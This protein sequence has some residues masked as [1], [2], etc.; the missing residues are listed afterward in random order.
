M[1]FLSF[2]IVAVILLAKLR[3]EGSGTACEIEEFRCSDHQCTF[4]DWVC[5]GDSDCDNGRDEDKEICERKLDCKSQN[6]FSCGTRCIPFHWHCD[7]YE[8]CDNGQDEKG[9]NYSRSCSSEE[10]PCY[11]NTVPCV[12]KSWLCDGEA[13]CPDG[14]DERN[15]SVSCPL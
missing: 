9:C 10:I 3:V 1:A 8:D 2:F 7:H 13:D 6:K 15:C 4:K 5:D 12:R 14:R 11:N